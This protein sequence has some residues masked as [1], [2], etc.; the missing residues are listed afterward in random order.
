MVLWPFLWSKFC[1]FIF[2]VL[3]YFLQFSNF[4]GEAAYSFIDLI[5]GSLES[6]C[7]FQAYNA[8]IANSPSKK[9]ENN[10]TID[11]G[12]QSGRPDLHNLIY[13][14]KSGYSVHCRD[15]SWCTSHKFSRFNQKTFYGQCFNLNLWC[16][17]TGKISHYFS[18]KLMAVF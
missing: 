4:V 15:S 12:G 16:T 3:A 8:S 13:Q 6:I 14:Y 1:G 9:S 10:R 11:S 18:S 2:M 17:P 5:H 7:P